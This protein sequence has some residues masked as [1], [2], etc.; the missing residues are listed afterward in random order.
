MQPVRRFAVWGFLVLALACPS[1]VWAD[2]EPAMEG[3]GVNSEEK[4]EKPELP[5]KK[6]A[7]KEEK[8]AGKMGDKMGQAMSQLSVDEMLEKYDTDMDG[9]LSQE[10]LAE[11]KGA[12]VDDLL[13]QHGG[14]VTKRFDTNGDGQLD[15]AEKAEMDSKLGGMKSRMA[16]AFDAMV[17]KADGD[18]DGALSAGELERVR[19]FQK[20]RAMGGDQP[21][22]PMADKMGGGRDMVNGLM[23]ADANGDGSLS[24]D[25]LAEAG[26][27][28]EEAAVA[29]EMPLL[30]KRY[31]EDGDGQLSAEE[32]VNLDD[33]VKVVRLEASN[34]IMQMLERFD[35]N[36]DGSLDPGEMSAV[37]D[38]IEGKAEGK[39]KEGKGKKKKDGEKG[40]EGEGEGEEKEE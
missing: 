26:K 29:A 25:E 33:H 2:E 17:T 9:S 16:Q 6:E 14:K 30:Q 34:K 13:K 21:G 3:D 39:G 40:K 1:R 19:E 38:A 4:S 18:K 8:R 36:K 12:R 5:T 37:K 7:K 35:G 31:D 15:E 27:K 24:R 11:M 22:M 32:Q 20:M 23:Q 10:E 28:R